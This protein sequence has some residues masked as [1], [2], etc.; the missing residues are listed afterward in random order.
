MRMMKSLL[1]L[2]V[3]S[4]GRTVGERDRVGCLGDG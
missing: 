2:V 4:R 1:L 3:V